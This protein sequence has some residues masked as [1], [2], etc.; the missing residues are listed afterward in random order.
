[1]FEV[2]ITGNISFAIGSNRF[3][4]RVTR[5]NFKSFHFLIFIKGKL[6]VKV[7][8]LTNKCLDLISIHHLRGM[9]RCLVEFDFIPTIS[10]GWAPSGV[11]GYDFLSREKMFRHDIKDPDE[12][13]SSPGGSS[14]GSI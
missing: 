6:S 2:L 13:G 3:K 11:L 8:F 9:T 10:L 1:M 14:P 7:I 4:N 5:T 12:G